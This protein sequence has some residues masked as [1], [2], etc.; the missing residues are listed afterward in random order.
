MA[1]IY[2]SD[3]TLCNNPIFSTV[4]IYKYFNFLDKKVIIPLS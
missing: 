3:P 4:H 2:K 1:F